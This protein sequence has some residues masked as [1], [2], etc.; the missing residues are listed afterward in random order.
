MPPSE[1]RRMFRNITPGDLVIWTFTDPEISERHQWLG[2]Y[3]TGART[4]TV[5]FNQ[6]RR[7]LP[8]ATWSPWEELRDD[9]GDPATELIDLPDADEERITIGIRL[10]PRVPG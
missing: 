2:R 10:A 4:M 5:E 6:S 3:L 1:V 9:D 8:S 7:M